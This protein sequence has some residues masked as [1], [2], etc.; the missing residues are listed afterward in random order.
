ME[1]KTS[2]QTKARLFVLAVF[3][4]AFAAGAL[5]MNLYHRASSNPDVERGRGPGRGPDHIVEKMS[6]KLDLSADQQEKIRGILGETFE[7]Y[8][9]IR[10]EMDPEFSKYKPRFDAV[11][12]RGREKMRQVLTEEQL[13]NFEVMIQEQDRQRE[14]EQKRR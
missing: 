5:S 11:R 8:K 9:K 10:E 2:N 6:K 7:E 1:S 12:Q 3:V 14:E 13:P 4:I